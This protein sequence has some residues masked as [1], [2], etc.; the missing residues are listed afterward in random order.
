MIRASD[1]RVVQELAKQYMEY[2]SSP[3]QSSAFERMKKTND[4][5]QQ[6]PPVL[7]DEIPWYQMDIDGELKCVSQDERVR[8]VEYHFRK[9]LYYFRHFPRADSLYEPFFRVEKTVHATGIGVELPSYEIQRTDEF[10][11]IVSR[12]LVDHLQDEACLARFRLPQ[13]SLDPEADAQRLDFLNELLGSSIPLHVYGFGPF[14]LNKWDTIAFLRGMEA[15]LLDAYDRPEYLVALFQKYIDYANAY[16]DFIEAHLEPDPDAPGMHCT[17][18]LVSGLGRG[19]KGTW[20]RDNAQ[21]LA[22]VS[23]KMFE[24]FAVDPIIALAS[25]FAYTYY[26]CCEPLDD[27]VQVLKKIPNLRKVGC[28]PWA[29]VNRMA[30]ELG[31]DYVLASKPNPAN[32]AVKTEP[33]LIRKEIVQTVEACLR[34]GCPFELVLKD[35]STVSNRPA[36][37]IQWQETVGEVLDEYFG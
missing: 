32:V 8:E 2:A 30:E 19:L 3:K 24:R 33:E 26:G 25:R 27:K 5:I 35:I 10:N 16:L 11:N 23:P 1:K 17:P 29:D 31:P 36:N 7:L 34:C 14:C 9:A 22:N 12:S 28:A 18:A 20:F 4:L 6:R 37:L 13:M 15:I 21:P